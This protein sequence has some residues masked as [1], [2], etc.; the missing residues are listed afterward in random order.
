MIE[1]ITKARPYAKAIFTIAK[2]NGSFDEWLNALKILSEIALNPE[3]QRILRDSTISPESLT[4]LFKEIY[5]LKLSEEEDNLLK[6]LA[7]KKRLSV[8]P[9]ILMF[10][11]RLCHEREQI[12]PLEF[13]SAIPLTE[14]QKTEFSDFLS[15]RFRKKIE[16]HNTVNPELLGGF[17]IK[18]GDQVIDGSIRGHLEQLKETIGE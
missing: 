7:L 1:K 5:P 11:E 16:M 8:L 18:A 17:W 14:T 2:G 3:M 13:V 15:K 12:L 6:L 9:E 10:Y 4:K